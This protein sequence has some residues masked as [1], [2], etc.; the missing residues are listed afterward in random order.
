[1]DSLLVL[2]EKGIAE[3]VLL[4][5]QSRQTNAHAGA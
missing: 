4:Q 2:A 5:K 3:L 1:M